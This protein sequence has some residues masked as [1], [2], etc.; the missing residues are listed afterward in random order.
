MYDSLGRFC[1][2]CYLLVTVCSFFG[3]ILIARPQF[4]FGSPHS[5]QPMVDT[6]AERMISVTSE[7]LFSLHIFT[8]SCRTVQRSLALSLLPVLV[9]LV[10]I[11][12]VHALSRF[13]QSHSSVQSG[14]GH[15]Q[16]T[17][18]PFSVRKVYCFLQ[19]GTH[20]TLALNVLGGFSFNYYMLLV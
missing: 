17:V 6:P 18:S 8:S 5:D 10:Y 7:I 16:S 13:P 15:M 14:N 11:E 3:V 19:W 1:R 9:S 12:V 2:A 20:P 4:L